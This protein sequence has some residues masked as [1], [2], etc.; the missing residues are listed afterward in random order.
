LKTKKVRKN[1]LKGRDVK[2]VRE[3]NALKYRQNNNVRGTKKNKKKKK[4]I[5]F[6]LHFFGYF[7]NC[8]MKEMSPL[9]D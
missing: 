6:F 2:R 8:E 5:A 3:E 1:N 9:F 7:R 4:D